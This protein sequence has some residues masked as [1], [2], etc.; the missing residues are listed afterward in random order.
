MK[1][2]ANALLGLSFATTAAVAHESHDL[3]Y[4][5]QGDTS[6]SSFCKA[7]TEDNVGLMHNSF[8]NKVGIVGVNKKDVFRKLLDAQNL[9]C[10]G[11]S[12]LE[13]SAQ[14]KAQNVLTYLEK[15]AAK[16]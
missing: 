1:L 8:R 12:L 13:F 9:T 10:N 5:F 16:L 15:N 4:V 2:F 11:K 6:Y 7:V 14:Y 3:E